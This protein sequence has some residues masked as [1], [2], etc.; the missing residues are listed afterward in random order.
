MLLALGVLALAAMLGNHIPPSTYFATALGVV[1]LGLLAGSILGRAR[2][3]IFLGILLTIALAVSTVAERIHIPD[4]A[5]GDVAWRPTS[6]AELAPRYVHRFGN[7]TL[8]LREAPITGDYRTRV[9]L[10][11]GQLTVLLPPDLDAV[12]AAQTGVGGLQILGHTGG[13]PDHPVHVTDYGQDGRGRAAVT[14]TL[15]V[16]AGKVEVRR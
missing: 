13:G 12:V 2:G 15:D 6:A 8:D 14:M 3:L 16:G 9:E 1:A 10:G 11:A 5:D 4:G 7:A